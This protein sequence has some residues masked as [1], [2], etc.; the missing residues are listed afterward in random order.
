MDWAS[1]TTYFKEI[2]KEQETYSKLSG[3][4][5]KRPCYKSVAMAREK[6]EERARGESVRDNSE[7]DL[8]KEVRD[9]IARLSCEKNEESEQPYKAE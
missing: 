6:I 1:A 3:Q 5:S 7:A 8:G 4:T 2:I 9:Y